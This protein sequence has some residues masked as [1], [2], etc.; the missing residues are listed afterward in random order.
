MTVDC[1]KYKGRLYDLCTGRG[2]EGRPDPSPEATALFLER[3][4]TDPDW[5]Q[6]AVDRA[7]RKFESA[8]RTQ[9]PT[10]HAVSFS[11]SGGPGTELFLLLVSLN[12]Q[13]KL[14]C[15]C[16]S[17]KSEMNKLGPAGCRE[18]RDSLVA[19]IRD[20][21]EKYRV[22]EWIAAGAAAIVSGLAFKLNPIDPIP[23][24]FDEAVCRAEK[25]GKNA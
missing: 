11:P 17:V 23:G 25:K 24:L 1:S 18:N 3:D 8:A 14:G 22:S 21:S 5:R 13:P 2:H 19:K 9:T 12:I 10:P 20:N 7:R 4:L 16:N 6:K 15:G